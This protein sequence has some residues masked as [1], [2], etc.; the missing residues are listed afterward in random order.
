MASSITIHKSNGEKAGIFPKLLRRMLRYLG[1][2]EWPLYQG[3]EEVVNGREEWRVE[4]LIDTQKH[5][6]LIFEAYGRRCTFEAGICDAARQAIS[7]VRDMYADELSNTPYRYFPHRRICNTRKRIC[8]YNKHP[9][10]QHDPNLLIQQIRLTKALDAVCDDALDELRETRFMLR[11]REE[12]LEALRGHQ[13]IAADAAPPPHT[14]LLVNG[15]EGGVS[16]GGSSAISD[17]ALR[18]QAQEDRR[19][20]TVTAPAP[21]RTRSRVVLVGSRRAAC[22]TSLRSKPAPTQRAPAPSPSPWGR[23]LARGGIVI[24]ENSVSFGSG[25]SSIITA[26]SDAHPRGQG[27]HRPPST[28]K[29]FFMHPAAVAVEAPRRDRAPAASS[30]ASSAYEC[31]RH[32]SNLMPIIADAGEALGKE[33]ANANHPGDATTTTSQRRS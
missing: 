30:A 22:R 15:N 4:V 19:P 7:R 25:G 11:E 23:R 9:R 3:F 28:Q 27:R 33:P 21:A 1:H 14:A 8:R 26:A 24:N 31:R 16:F 32:G 10:R 20:G 6:P 12:E 17:G 5:K 13:A 2:Q 18:P 29:S